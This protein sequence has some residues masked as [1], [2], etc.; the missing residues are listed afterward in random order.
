MSLKNCKH[1]ALIIVGEMEKGVHA[2]YREALI[3]E[4]SRDQL[5]GTAANVEY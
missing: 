3:D 4:I 1:P 2:I 5:A